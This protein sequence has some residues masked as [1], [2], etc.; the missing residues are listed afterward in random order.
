MHDIAEPW[1]VGGKSCVTPGVVVITCAQA[2]CF[3]MHDITEPC[4]VGGKPC[5]KPW[6]D[7][8]EFTQKHMFSHAEPR[9]APE[10][11]REALS[12]T[13]NRCRGTSR[14]RGR[15]REFLEEALSEMLDR[16]LPAVF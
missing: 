7:I 3:H 11:P 13:E 16:C 9:T 12:E 2:I 4:V 5:A 14:N 8:S 6:I 1:V 10:E 15:N